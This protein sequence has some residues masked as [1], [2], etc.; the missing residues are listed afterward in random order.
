MA[1][2]HVLPIDELARQLRFRAATS[3][4]EDLQVLLGACAAIQEACAQGRSRLLGLPHSLL[5]HALALCDMLTLARLDCCTKLLLY[6]YASTTSTSTS[7]SS[8]TTG[9][10]GRETTGCCY[11]WH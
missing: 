7:T 2:S 11:C 6:S 3:A 10:N 5:V 1:E 9:T 8:T 4:S